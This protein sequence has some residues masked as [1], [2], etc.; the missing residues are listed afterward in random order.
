MA[1][2]RLLPLVQ[3]AGAGLLD[4]IVPAQ[5]TTPASRSAPAF[6]NEPQS[7]SMQGNT[8]LP[9][10]VLPQQVGDS[11]APMQP[12]GGRFVS[13]EDGK[14][15]NG[16]NFAKPA[17]VE[18]PWYKRLMNDP[19][20]IA[21]LGIGFNSMRLNPDAALTQVLSDRIKTA[22]EMSARNQT[23]EKVSLA[24]KNQGRFEEAALVESNPD[25]AKTVL[26]AMFTG[27]RAK[28]F[29]FASGAQLNEK[30][31]TDVFDPKKPYKVSSAGEISEIGGSGTTITNTNELGQAAGV[32]EYGKDWAASHV[33]FADEVN[34]NAD[35]SA[36]L[37]SQVSN[38]ASN[39]Q[40]LETGPFEERVAGLRAFAGSIGFPVDKIQLGREQSVTAAARQ[41]VADQLRMN[42]GPQTDFD[43]KFAETY[44]PGFGKTEDANNQIIAYL[45]STN[46]LNVIFANL[47]GNVAGNGY[48]EERKV[49]GDIRDLRRNVPAVAKKDGKW[50]QF[51][52]YYDTI[53]S[54]DSSI[55]DREILTEWKKRAR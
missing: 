1:T 4:R 23:A 34:A 15:Y 43:A 39:L 37:L 28:T 9:P 22:G 20:A 50:V 55:S 8:L 14:M 18:E 10:Y 17:P 31:G 19:A 48:E 21:Q 32:K 41:M 42:K 45:R 7:R 11:F 13:N 25:M 29:T 54:Q 27:D 44:L 49:I 2:P 30:G 16:Q 36:S 24:L 5:V 53:K 52:T 3:Q 38:I 51:S 26:S 40:G 35:N 12:G 46:Q 6:A 47:M 33:K